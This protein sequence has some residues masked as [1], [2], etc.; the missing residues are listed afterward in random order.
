[1]SDIDIP[2]GRR[3]EGDVVIFR[4]AGDADKGD[5]VRVYS[6]FREKETDLMVYYEQYS[7]AFREIFGEYKHL[8]SE[9]NEA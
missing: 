8:F 7:T 9:D 2:A 3:V 4:D 5:W 6:G 1:M